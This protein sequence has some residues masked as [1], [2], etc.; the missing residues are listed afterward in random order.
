M[1]QIHQDQEKLGWKQ[2]YYNQI[3]S[4]WAQSLT[5]SQNTIKGI[6]LF[7]SRVVILIWQAVIA[8][9]KVHNQH[10]HPP[11]HTKEDC[12]QLECMVY[13]IIQEAQ[14]DPNMQD[15]ITSFNPNAL[16]N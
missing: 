1:Q 2:I 14:S 4:V 10:L 9:W 11:N 12:T 5:S 16:L 8:L 13:Q 6:V 7:H 15:L 3:T